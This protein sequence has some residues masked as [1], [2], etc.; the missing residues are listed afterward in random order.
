MNAVIL[1][2]A[3]FSHNWGGR[4]AK[5][6]FQQLI[7]NP[8]IRKSERLIR[9]LWQHNAAGGFEDALA[10]VQR[11]YQLDPD[12]HA[13]E[14]KVLQNAVLEMFAAMNEGYS[15]K[16]DWEFQQ[17][18]AFMVRTF[19]VQFRA[20]FSLNQDLLLEHKYL[21]DNVML[22]S[23]GKWGGWQIPGMKLSV[24]SLEPLQERATGVWTPTG[25]VQTDARF[26]PIY[27]LHGSVN[28]RDGSN[29]ALMII[30]GDKAQQIQT[31]PVLSAYAQAFEGQ[32]TS[33]ETR[34]MIIGYGF[35][36]HHINQVIARAV[37]KHDLQFFVI[38]PEGAKVAETFRSHAHPGAAMTAFGYDLE[39]VFARGCSG[40]ST[41]RLSD[42][43]G[44]DYGEHSQVIRFVNPM[45]KRRH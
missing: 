17:D 39:D 27:K 7:G 13:A 28:W 38:C 30:G 42:I 16:I 20:I 9:L 40:F 23:D 4:L 44:T 31:H 1:L 33:G 32:L 36:D 19:L 41:R 34:L 25:S 37:Y 22:G 26:Q 29:H 15:A 12:R 6:V 18:R 43:F 14:L 21:N 5:E 24:G 10:E 2:G 35:R 45:Y 8:E 3:G 11:D